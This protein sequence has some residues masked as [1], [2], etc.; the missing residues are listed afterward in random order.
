MQ[1]T[2]EGLEAIIFTSEGD[3]RQAVNNLQSTNSGFSLVNPINVYKVCDQPHPFAIQAMIT[4]CIAGQLD[5]AL[6]RLEKVWNQ[7]FA[8]VDI[9]TTIFKVVKAM[10]MSEFL[11]LEYIKEIGYVHMRLLE[12]CHSLLQ[13]SAL[14]AKLVSLNQRI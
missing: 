14:V 5:D 1:Y 10:D 2:N 11:K 3:M 13:M 9:I 8:S 6:A 4:A 7:G 12:G